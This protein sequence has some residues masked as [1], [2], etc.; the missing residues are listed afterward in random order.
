MEKLRALL[1]K[2]ISSPQLVNVILA[3]LVFVAG[4]FIAQAV[5]RLM[6]GMLHKV[7]LDERLNKKVEGTPVQLEGVIAKFVYYILLIYILMMTLEL[8]GVK[9]VLDPLENA[10]TKIFQVIPDAIAAIFIGFLGYIL[11]KVV[12]SIVLAATVGFDSVASKAGISKSLTVSKV[13][14]KIVFI[15]IFVPSAIAALDKLNI[16]AISDPAKGMLTSLFDAVPEILGAAGVLVLAY[17]VGK[18]VTGFLSDFLKDLGSDDVPKKIG[19]EGLFAGKSFS[20]FC[21]NICFFF[22]M[23]SASVFAV[24]V[25]NVPKVTEIMGSLLLFVGNIVVGLIIL[26]IGSFIANVA[27]DKLAA[28]SKSTILPIIAKVAI[29]CFVITM[30]LHAMKVGDKIVEDAFIFACATISLTIILAFGLGG[31]EAAGKLM[32]HWLGKLKK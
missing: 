26:A 8:L 22:I 19:A 11:A 30:G 14:E 10:M 16:K 2:V 1:S 12:S 27:F 15:V 5:S 13:L 18:F 7:R 6:K 25:L 29:L 20:V 31:R 3:V 9:G 21:S 17:I 4:W 24:G 32:D 28:S 23:L